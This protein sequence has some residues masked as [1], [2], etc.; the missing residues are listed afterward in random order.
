MTTVPIAS[1]RLDGGTQPRDSVNTDVAKGYAEAIADGATLPPVTVFFDGN[2]YW[3]ADGFHRVLAHKIV[4][5]A[6]VAADIRQGTRRDAV[7]FSVGANSSHGLPRTNADKRRAVLVLINDEEWSCWSDREIARRCAVSHPTVSALRPTSLEKS[8]SEVRVYTDRHGNPSTMR[9]GEIGRPKRRLPVVAGRTPDRRPDPTFA[10]RDELGI[11]EASRVA[12]FNPDKLARFARDGEVPG[13]RKDDRTWVFETE[14]LQSWMAG[15]SIT[16][17]A[18]EPDECSD[19][20]LHEP[21]VPDMTAEQDRIINALA[22]VVRT[23]AVIGSPADALRA[24]GLFRGRLFNREDIVTAAAWLGTFAT[25]FPIVEAQRQR[26]V[27]AMLKEI[28]ADVL[29]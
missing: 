11:G 16:A 7:L 17:T 28:E 19:K 29:S 8:T 23:L 22:D 1:I 14:K 21:L 12:G 9:V 13:A 18:T 27:D 5:I 26:A 15:K 10:V 6:E 24:W 25:E 20:D 4:D 3:L 2:A